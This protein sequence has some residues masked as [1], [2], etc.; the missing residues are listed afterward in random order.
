[1]T[2]NTLS[3]IIARRYEELRALRGKGIEPFPHRFEKTH[4]ALEAGA[5][6]PETAVVCAGRIVQIRAM[7]KASF[8]HIQDGTGKVQIYLKKD[9]LG[10]QAYELFRK[11]IHVGDFAG[12]KGKIFLTHTGETTVS[13]EE[14]TLLSKSIRPLP[15]K[16]HGLNDTEIRF[17]QRHLDLIANA[18]VKKIFETRAAIVRSIRK[19]LDSRGFME[20]ET[21]ILCQQAGGAAATPFIT[22]HNA[23]E[24]DLYLR[25]ATEL[26]LKRLIIGG[27][28]RVYEIGRI[29]RNEGIDTRHNPE[30]TMLEAYQAYTDYNG[31]AK[32]LES[33]IEACAGETGLDS[34]KY[35]DAEISLKTPFRRL[36]LPEAWKERCG[37]DIHEILNGKAFRREGLLSLAKK[38]G[39]EHS[40]DTPSAK[41]FE[42]I[43]D[44]RILPLLEQPT[45]VM[46]YP[47]A[48]TPLAKCKPG[49]ESLVERFEFFAGTE[50]IA[51]AYTELNDPGDQM[52][53]LTEQMR[54]RQAEKNE[55]T[56]VLDRDFVEAMETGMPPTGGI[57]VGIDRLTMLLSG[58][59]S[60]RE[61]ILFPTLKPQTEAP[62]AEP[63]AKDTA[64]N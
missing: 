24:T 51:N 43:F 63:A 41:V 54:Q 3:E 44:A 10:E 58:K 20:A 61:V 16:W 26:Y 33:V 23:L 14:I 11:D 22:H 37:G 5:S 6:A 47:T 64:G 46:D 8:A 56:D 28:D 50:E 36:P 30:F 9:V 45:F 15:E 55:D 1:M 19:T 12:I 52:G 49:D 27:M 39:I 32:L 60:I 42:R 7:G 40:R 4:S 31:M 17:R 35:R 18:E 53:R 13:A 62:D 59:P 38:L 34:V 2:Q 25:I 57:G 29:F 48:I 21:P